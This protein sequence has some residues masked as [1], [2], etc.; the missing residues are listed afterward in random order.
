MGVSSEGDVIG[1]IKLDIADV[2]HKLDQVQK[3]MSNTLGA[4]NAKFAQTTQSMTQ[5]S[6]NFA[7]MARGH[8]KTFSASWWARFG[9]IAIGFSIAY[10]SMQAVETVIRKVASTIGDAIGESSELAAVQAKLAFWYTLHSEKL[11]SYNEALERASANTLALRNANVTAISTMQELTTGL[12]EIAQSVGSVPAKMIPAMADLV[13]FTVMVAQ[14]TGSTTRQIRQEFQALMEGRIR[15]TDVMARSLIKTGILTKEELKQMRNMTNQAEILEK[16]LTKL[17]ERWSEAREQIVESS[18]ELASSRWEKALRL[19]IMYAIQLAS[20]MDGVRN[21]FAH[22]F[23]EHARK[24]IDRSADSLSRNVDMIRLLAKGLDVGLTF[25]EK[26]MAVVASTISFIYRFSSEI[27]A[28]LKVLIGLYVISK[29]NSLLSTFSSVLMTLVTGPIS[30]AGK[31]ISA[32]V[33]LF[34]VLSS[35]ILT[36]PIAIYLTTVAFFAFIKT[37]GGDLSQMIADIKTL[38]S[39]MPDFMKWLATKIV[40]T[41]GNVFSKLWD[42]LPD[43]V[44]AIINTI[45]SFLSEVSP[46]VKNFASDFGKNFT[47]II[48]GNIDDIK[49]LLGPLFK[50]LSGGND[51]ALK[52]MLA[53]TDKYLKDL[54]WTFNKS[55][56]EDEKARK[57]RLRRERQLL[58]LQKQMNKDLITSKVRE[59]LQG[60]DDEFKVRMVKIQDRTDL[61]G[62]HNEAAWKEYLKLAEE[63]LL[64]RDEL[65]DLANKARAAKMKESLFNALKFFSKDYFDYEAQRIRD[66]LKAMLDAGVSKVDAQRWVYEELKQLAI[67]HNN[68]I[69][70]YS[71]GFIEVGEAAWRNYVLEAKTAMQEVAELSL[72]VTDTFTS[73]IGDAF[74]QAYIYGENLTSNLKDLAKEMA[75]TIISTLIR[76]GLEKAIQWAA[77][78]VLDVT[79]AVT[80]MGNLAMETYA[81]AFAS[82]VQTP[83]IGPQI[84][85]AV[86]SSSLA[87]M[88]SGASLAKGLGS[89]L[90]TYDKGGVNLVPGIFYS[91]VPEAHVPLKDGAIPVETNGK[92]L[93]LTILNAVDMSMLDQYLHTSRGQDAIV[94]VI[95]KRALTVKRVL[96]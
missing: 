17:S 48:K 70:K 25:F 11:I 55:G 81:G 80:K 22:V 56:E 44:K 15:T 20:K 77:D 82:A 88:L 72:S 94:N 28:L 71:R 50:A 32:L 66:D 18:V 6:E 89:A 10:R 87:A 12:D 21:I 26:F 27:S 35:S 42:V 78:K 79:S 65:E 9:E 90:G 4:L 39:S 67:D 74:A 92:S 58:Q 38:F 5:K 16:V 40:E 33:M 84:A 86:A 53:D 1:S 95:S 45:T 91:G 8:A 43:S 85:P 69:I 23:A 60:I 52:K 68:F 64:K 24:L 14:T 51:E 47:G 62:K 46:K 3:M 57:E 54:G 31:A 7:H 41:F 36:I 59:T 37:I 30:L 73:G 2:Q 13:D 96:R 83:I 63:N 75:S 29:I 34:R 61:E 19:E 49:N 76:I 93:D